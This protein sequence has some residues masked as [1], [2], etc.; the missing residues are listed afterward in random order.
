MAKEGAYPQ[1]WWTSRRP[2]RT[3][4]LAVPSNFLNNLKPQ[5]SLRELLADPKFPIAKKHLHDAILSPWQAGYPGPEI[6]SRR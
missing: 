1:P 5:S 6:P 2:L 4:D 3:R